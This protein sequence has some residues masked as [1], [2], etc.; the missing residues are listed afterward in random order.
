MTL[1]KENI[2]ESIILTH[3]WRKSLLTEDEHVT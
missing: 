2:I 3:V 1:I